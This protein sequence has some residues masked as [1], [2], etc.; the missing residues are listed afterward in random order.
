MQAQMD[1]GS[2]NKKY[3]EEIVSNDLKENPKVFWSYVLSKQQESTGVAQM[4]NKDGFIHGDSSSKVEI[5]NDQ[6]VS[7]YTREDKP[8]TPKKGTS[9]LLLWIQSKCIETAF[10][11]SSET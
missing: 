6:F 8:N 10:S 11:S 4:K 9:D 5:L 7:A 3:M 2:A 1:M